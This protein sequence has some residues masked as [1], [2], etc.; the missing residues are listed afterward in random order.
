MFLSQ[1]SERNFLPSNAVIC[2]L[3][4]VPFHILDIFTCEN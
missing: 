3:V 4:D 2:N 1:H